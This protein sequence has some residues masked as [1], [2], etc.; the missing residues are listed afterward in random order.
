MWKWSAA[1][2][3]KMATIFVNGCFDLLHEGH[4]TFLTMA[5]NLG[6]GRRGLTK[7]TLAPTTPHRLI[8]AVNS[9][10]YARELKQARWGD[11]YPRDPLQQR[12][13]R[14][15]AFADETWSFDD[16]GSLY[17]LIEGSLPC[18]LCKGPDY[19]DRETEVTGSDIAPVIILDTPETEEIRELKRKAYM[20]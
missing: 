16:E 19:A 9:D 14:L 11:N 13:E 12:I 1:P 20:L 17:K 6:H 2:A 10:R 5:K 18:I 15:R 4:R 8:V 3:D 7:W